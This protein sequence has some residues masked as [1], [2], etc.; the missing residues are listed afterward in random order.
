MSLNTSA[1]YNLNYCSKVCIIVRHKFFLIHCT[2]MQN[3]KDRLH[4]IYIYIKKKT[5]LRFLIDVPVYC[6]PEWCAMRRWLGAE[7]SGSIFD[8]CARESSSI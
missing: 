8:L 1:F 2:H 4:G 3:L 5:Y 6:W 7:Y